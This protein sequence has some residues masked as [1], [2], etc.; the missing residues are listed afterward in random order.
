MATK[1]KVK[2]VAKVAQIAQEVPERP[3]TIAEGVNVN[4]YLPSTD[5]NLVGKNQYIGMRY[6]PRFF[7]DWNSIISYEPLSIV[8]WSDEKGNKGQYISK[9]FTTIGKD[10][11]NKDEWLEIFNFTP[12][13]NDLVKKVNENYSTLDGKID[14][15]KEKLDAKIV[16]NQ[17][18]ITEEAQNRAEAD[19]QTNA[20]VTTNKQEID[21]LD[22]RVGTIEDTIQ[23]IPSEE[24]LNSLA[25]N[26]NTAKTNIES[27]QTEDTTIK[28]FI[29]DYTDNI[30][31]K[32]ISEI[33]F[34]SM[35][36]YGEHLMIS[37]NLKFG[38]LCAGG[39][40]KIGATGI[41]VLPYGR[42]EETFIKCDEIC[43]GQIDSSIGTNS[44]YTCGYGM[45]IYNNTVRTCSAGLVFDG[46][47]TFFGIMVGSTDRVN[48]TV[49]QPFSVNATFIFD[50]SI[51]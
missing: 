41:N 35:N 42:P 29:N 32:R 50:S 5:T 30:T 23:A 43:N 22:T 3:E 26:V 18:A 8:D 34:D 7:G 27:L 24:V 17:N 16:N 19:R 15:E 37:K 25:D 14:S 4:N 6:V 28:N 2:E 46:E 40:V 11:S 9:W 38:F 20:N 44:F 33:S 36:A 1:K 48:V 39:E 45:Y 10:P 47:K 51:E 13:F 12:A 31:H 21:S 49:A